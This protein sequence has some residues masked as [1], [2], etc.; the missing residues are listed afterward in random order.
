M[1]AA[2]RYKAL[3]IPSWYHAHAGQYE[4]MFR[5][6]GWTERQVENA[7]RFGATF[8]GD[9]AALVR[10]FR[11]FAAAE[12][13][14][15]NDIDVATT[16]GMGMRDDINSNGV[17]SLPA[18]PA[19]GRTFTTSDEKR[20]AE[21]RQIC[22]NNPDGITKDLQTEWTDLIEAQQASGGRVVA[23]GAPK[24]ASSSSTRSAEIRQICRDDPQR[25]DNSP[26]LQREWLGLIE[27]DLAVQSGTPSEAPQQQAPAE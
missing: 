3:G 15:I 4:R 24:P 5:N 20:L 12:G 6:M 27:A 10:E 7:L 25:Y 23:D 11:N 8:N 14:T 21:L 26:D 22:R 13:I 9:E 17:E 18:L 16:V 19:E 2:E 1:K